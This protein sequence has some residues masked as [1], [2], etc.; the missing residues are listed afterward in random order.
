[1]AKKNIYA[2]IDVGSN[3]IRFLI[4]KIDEEKNTL[5]NIYRERVSLSLGRDSFE[6]GEISLATEK[7]L[8]A[9]FKRFNELIDKNVIPRANIRAVGTSALRDAKNGKSIT[10]KILIKTTI[11]IKILTG[12]EEAESV[13]FA[14]KKSWHLNN[15][16]LIFMDLGGGSLEFNLVVKKQLKYSSSVDIGTVRLLLAAKK[17]IKAYEALL[18]DFQ[19]Q[20]SK[21]LCRLEEVS[22]T[23]FSQVPLIG[24]GGNLRCLG[25]LRKK[26]LGKSSSDF[27][28][29][30]D[31]EQISSIIRK[32]S[33]KKRI[34]EFEMR[35][36]RAEVIEGALRIIEKVMTL[37]GF[38]KIYLPNIG[39]IHGIVWQLYEKNS[40]KN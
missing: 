17:D 27:A 37:G 12:L 23:S 3:A 35:K 13:Y 2:A 26:L 9:T 33:V 38:E 15:H 21:V 18:M 16:P 39:L 5:I 24:T 20:L 28:K 6:N 11:P 40:Q 25:S 8:I 4:S 29:K 30:K 34:D 7:E 31:V 19:T 14:F 22:S 36:D 32:T 1:M 10:E